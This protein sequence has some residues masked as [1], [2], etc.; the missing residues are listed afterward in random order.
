M[1]K[2]V[3]QLIPFTRNIS[4]YRYVVLAVLSGDYFKESWDYSEARANVS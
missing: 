1:M 2:P 3:R 4:A